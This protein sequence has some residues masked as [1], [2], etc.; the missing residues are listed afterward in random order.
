MP[1]STHLV[2]PEPPKKKKEEALFSSKPGTQTF[3]K[4]LSLTLHQSHRGSICMKEGFQFNDIDDDSGDDADDNGEDSNHLGGVK[5]NSSVGAE[6]K[7]AYHPD[8]MRCLALV[9]HNGMKEAM[10]SFVVQHKNVLKKFRLTG[11]ASTMK[12]LHHVFGDDADIVFGPA[13]H[14]GPLG[15]DAELVAMMTQGTLGGIFFF[16]DPMASHPH[17]HDIDCLVRQAMVHN[18][19]IVTTPTTAML[20][21]EG[22][23][24]ALIGNGRPELIPSFFLSLECPTVEAYKTDQAAVV[25]RRCSSIL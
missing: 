19:L 13:C 7:A 9:S 2:H 24:Q 20:T 10:Q 1:T 6:F 12:M 17:Q 14:S 4:R 3:N 18:T 15:G 5:D 11:T 16:E 8:E 25:Q 21:V 22:F 23:R